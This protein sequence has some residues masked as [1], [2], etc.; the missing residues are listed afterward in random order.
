MRSRAALGRHPIH[1]ALVTVPIGAFALVAI[2]DVAML[3]T[4]PGPFW[5]RF[6]RAALVVGLASAALAAVFG[7]I[8]YFGVKMSA[9]AGRI[10][11]TH[12][13][14]NVLA[15]AAYGAS[16]AL[17]WGDDPATGGPPA[18]A[19]A[20]A[21]AAFATLGVSGWLGGKLA[22]EHKVGVVENADPEATEIGRREPA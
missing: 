10:A 21:F 3:V 6:S 22:F 12:F 5:F 16:L 7:L 2:G 19:I 14:L 15:L 13:V 18:A 11:T 17:R 9:A 4:E 1:P 8:D 20:L